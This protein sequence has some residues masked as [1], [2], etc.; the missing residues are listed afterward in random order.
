MAR[1]EYAAPA[2][3]TG[4]L[5]TWSERMPPDPRMFLTFGLAGGTAELVMQLGQA[6]HDSLELSERSVEIAAAVV[7]HATDSPY[8][9]F[10]HRPP[11]DVLTTAERDALLDGA[12]DVESFDE[13]DRA[14]LQF[15]K[16]LVANPHVA[17]DTFATAR[18]HLS[19]RELVELV[20][21]FSYYW[22]LG[23]LDGALQL[24]DRQS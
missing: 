8:L 2:T 22:M 6:I 9:R 12:D 13:R 5:R 7:T 10:R 20:Q 23:L 19:D 21:S 15:A 4:Q 3:F 16:A 11:T 24:G 17:D 14:V 1:I 18:P